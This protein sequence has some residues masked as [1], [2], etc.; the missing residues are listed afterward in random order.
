MSLTAL[1]LKGSIMQHES[2]NKNGFVAGIILVSLGLLLLIGQSFRFNF[3]WIFE[4]WNLP[5]PV[6]VIGAGLLLMAVGLLA[7]RNFTGFTILGSIVLVSGL[8]LAFQNATQTYQTWAYLWALVFP[9]SIGLAL[10][11]QSVV[12]HDAEQRKTGLRMM[13][14][15]LVLTIVF[16]SFFEGAINLSN[17]GLNSITNLVGPVLLIG[18]GAWLLISQGFFSKGK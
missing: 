11:T 14:V 4:N 3:F 17:F 6:I 7:G 13:A 8:L 18:I 16:W 9:G 15:A 12:T 1:V 2:T 10:A 5:Y